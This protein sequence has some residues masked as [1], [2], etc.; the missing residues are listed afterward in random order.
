MKQDLINFLKENK[1]DAG[2]IA[3]AETLE[4]VS[5]ESI[6]GYLEQNEEGKKYLQSQIDSNVTKGIET[7]KSKTMPN[8]IEEEIK[9]KFPA[10]TDEQKRVRLLEENFAKLQNE[11]KRKDLLNIALKKANEKKLPVE[12][13]ESFLGEDEE[14]TV[15]KIDAF[16][17]IFNNALKS[18]VE[19]RFKE[20]S[21]EPNN[22]NGNNNLDF[23]YSKMSDEEYYKQRLKQN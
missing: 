16:E 18:N 23:D 6:K 2:I 10:E 7:F 9:K 5:L 13:I 11:A 14:T 15:K 12:L 20:H 21:R 19:D 8:L 22:N 17:T 1:A 3:F 4:A